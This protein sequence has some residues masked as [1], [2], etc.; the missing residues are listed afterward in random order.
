MGVRSTKDITLDNA[1]ERIMHI[2][3][4]VE[5]KDYRAIESATCE[6]DFDVEDFVNEGCSFD[7]SREALAKWSIL[8]IERQID[9][10]FYR[11]SKYDSYAID[12]ELD[13]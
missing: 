2:A 9:K 7:Y 13:F 11:C 8:M 3:K 12:L 4:L 6:T 5:E 10:P 1:I